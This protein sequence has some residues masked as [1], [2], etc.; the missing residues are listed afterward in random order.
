MSP[1]AFCGKEITSTS[2]RVDGGGLDDDPAI[3]D[4]FLNVCAGVGVPNFCLLDGVEP[5]FTLADAS[6]GG[7]APVIL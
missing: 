2:A 3:L 1:L 6:D 5:D 4:K 7:G